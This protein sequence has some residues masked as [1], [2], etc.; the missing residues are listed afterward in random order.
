M[1]ACG[2]LFTVLALTLHKSQEVT[3]PV[4]QE[5]EEKKTEIISFSQ[6][7]VRIDK[8]FTSSKKKSKEQKDPP[9][10][11]TVPDVA[12]DLP[13]KEATIVKGYWE[14]FPDKAGFGTGSAYP[15]EKGNLVIFAHAKEGLFGP[16]K[17]V[18]SGQNVYVFTINNWYQYKI[19]SIRE[20][21]PS[22][23]EVIGP[24]EEEVLTLYTC[25]G[26]ADNK[27][28]IVTAKLASQ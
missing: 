14:V 3:P 17:N 11:I 2:V 22:Q 23:T 7:P 24:T 27:R 4:V 8:S 1:L 16:L 12:I 6:E 10:R 15:G 28:L 19:D 13:V 9:L 5:T 25:S 26:F 18:K 20:V 21:Y